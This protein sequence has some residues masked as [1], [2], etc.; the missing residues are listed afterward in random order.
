MRPSPRSV[1]RWLSIGG[2]PGAARNARRAVEDKLQEQW[3]AASVEARFSDEPL[4]PKR[5]AT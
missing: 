5:D 4:D 3:Q 2:A 1:L